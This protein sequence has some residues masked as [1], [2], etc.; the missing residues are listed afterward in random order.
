[1]MTASASSSSLA[2]RLPRVRGGYESMADLGRMTWF[3]VGGPAEV[4]FTPA[5]VTDLSAFL[6]AKPADVPVTVIGLG[7]NLLVRDGGVPGVL[8]RL[9]KAF[10]NIE[11]DGLSLRCGAIEAAERLGR[12]LVHKVIQAARQREVR[13]RRPDVRVHQIAGVRLQ[14]GRRGESR[15]KGRDKE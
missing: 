9:G 15:G 12:G 1:M 4:L 8:I 11:T 6:K 10:N 2:D 13:Q 5:D 3:R 7:S 14:R